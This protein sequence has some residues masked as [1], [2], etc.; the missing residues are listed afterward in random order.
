MPDQE[1]T[2]P[3]FEKRAVDIIAQLKCFVCSGQ[4][5]SQS[6]VRLAQDLRSFVRAQI[7][8]GKS[9]EEIL[10]FLAERYGESIFLAPPI[11][12]STIALWFLPFLALVFGA[13]MFWRGFLR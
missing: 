7:M 6:N 10:S 4:P 8:V 13:F 3:V 1:L 5:L 9:D 11:R 12:A 2:N